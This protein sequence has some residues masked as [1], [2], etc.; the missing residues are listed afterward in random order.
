MNLVNEKFA[1]TLNLRKNRRLVDIVEIG[2]SKTKISYQTQ[3][4][5]RSRFNNFE[6]S[7]KFLITPSITGY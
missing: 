3:T 5:I 7:L 1:R 4:T 2:V 6:V